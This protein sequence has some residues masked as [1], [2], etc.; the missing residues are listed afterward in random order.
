MAVSLSALGDGR[1]RRLVGC[2]TQ[3]LDRSDELHVITW[4]HTPQ[5]EEQ[6]AVMNS[7]ND[8]R[9]ARAESRRELVHRA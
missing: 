4:L 5:I 6:L 9:R 8:R 1:N 3:R 7:T 2:R